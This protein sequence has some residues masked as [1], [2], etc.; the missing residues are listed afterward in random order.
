MLIMGWENWRRWALYWCQIIC[1]WSWDILNSAYLQC[2]EWQDI[3]CE[4][5]TSYVN[6]F[7]FSLPSY[8]TSRPQ[9]LWHTLLRFSWFVQDSTLF[10]K[11]CHFSSS[12]CLI[13]YVKWIFFINLAHQ[14]ERFQNLLIF[15]VLI[16]Q[17][18]SPY[19]SG[20]RGSSFKDDSS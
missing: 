17:E 11:Y 14:M 2:V 7:S 3:L 20:K 16:H 8:S 10:H 13:V 9:T 5:Y 1:F 6:H 12:L 19:K 18:K 4:H 15:F